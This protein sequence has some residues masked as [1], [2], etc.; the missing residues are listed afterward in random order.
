MGQSNL[1]TKS[2]NSIFKLFFFADSHPAGGN[3]SGSGSAQASSS[4]PRTA[5]VS[6]VN[7]T[8]PFVRPYGLTLS[9]LV[10]VSPE[11]L[12]QERDCLA[13]CHKIMSEATPGK[14]LFLFIRN[15][16]DLQYINYCIGDHP[17]SPE[18]IMQKARPYNS[19][20]LR[21]G[22]AYRIS[23]LDYYLGKKK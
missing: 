3:N 16:K 5:T 8:D 1:T 20:T 18:Y 6:S 17:R 21:Q 15:S 4:Q 7:P 13:N 10:G 23:F 2:P 19:A 11:G 22:I 14:P 12:Q 9:G